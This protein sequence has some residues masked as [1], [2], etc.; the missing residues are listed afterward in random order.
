[1]IIRKL[2]Q[3]KNQKGIMAAE[4]YTPSISDLARLRAQIDFDNAASMANL[5]VRDRAIGE[6]C[7]TA[8]DVA[9]LL[10]WL[11]NIPEPE[12]A[13]HRP[14]MS[15]ASVAAIVRIGALIM[16]FAAMT[17]FLVS[18]GRLVNV[19]AFFLLFVVVQ[20]VFC[21]VSLWVIFRSLR[22]DPPT[23]LPINPLKYLFA[24]MVPDKRFYRECQSV[25]RI[26]VLRYGQEIGLIFTL[27][28]IL[29][30]FVVL[31]LSGFGFVWGSTFGITEGLVKGLVDAVSAPWAAAVSS[32][33]VSNDIIVASQFQQ[34]VT[35]FG[36][37]EILVTR[38]W[39]PFLIMSMSVYALLP[40][41]VL[42][43]FTKIAYRR[44]MRESLLASPGAERVLSR[45]KTPHVTTEGESSADSRNHSAPGT[46]LDGNPVIID[47]AGALAFCDRDDFDEL[48][49]VPTERIGAAGTGSLSEDLATA[50]WVTGLKPQRLL[51]VVKAW[52]PPMADLQDFIARISGV[53]RCTLCLLPLKNRAIKEAGI[54]DWRAFSRELAIDVVDVLVLDSQTNTGT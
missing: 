6:Q 35:Q 21:L 32:A 4:S 27:G 49:M 5:R 38:Q 13:G 16:G 1:L 47:W 18:G 43:W 22:D 51:V 28:A 8:D 39:W 41:A 23:V 40:R 11:K 50:Q 12:A 42:W 24:K 29:A 44:G 2:F 34:G 54:K 7:E 53:A 30:F 25:I 48:K 52:E 31:L 3:H 37:A 10:Y 20:V 14:A 15:E 19:F 26:L 17:S 33:V 45:M 9:R 46:A 36:N